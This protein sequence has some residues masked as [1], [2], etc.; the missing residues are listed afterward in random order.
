MITEMNSSVNKFWT[1]DECAE[2]L[3]VN[4]ATYAELW[5]VHAMLCDKFYPGANM[6]PTGGD[7]SNG[8]TEEPIHSTE[9]DNNIG[10]AWK[11]LSE[12]ARRNLNIAFDERNKN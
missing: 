8:T 9:Y 4:A 10:K 1:L 12:D 7:G 2:C 11:H 6:K 3:G 5:R